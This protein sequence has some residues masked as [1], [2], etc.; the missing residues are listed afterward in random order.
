MYPTSFTCSLSVSAAAVIPNR[1]IF[2]GAWRAKCEALYGITKIVQQAGNF[3]GG[4]PV[5]GRRCQLPVLADRY[6]CEAL[7]DHRLADS[8]IDWQ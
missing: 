7:Y 6:W 5:K 4:E 3:C 1:R 2:A 8:I